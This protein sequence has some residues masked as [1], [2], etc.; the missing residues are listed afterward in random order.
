MNALTLAVLRYLD[1]HPY[2]GATVQGG[3]ITFERDGDTVTLVG[4]APD[5][6]EVTLDFLRAAHLHVSFDERDGTLTL[7]VQPEPLRYRPLYI[8]E[9]DI[10]MCQR[11]TGE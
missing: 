2:A 5:H 9:Y 3:A 7:D 6:T 1:D 10:V 8:G 11:V 4:D